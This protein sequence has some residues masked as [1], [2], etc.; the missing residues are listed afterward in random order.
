MEL[1]TVELVLNFESTFQV[2]IPDPEAE[3]MMT[4]RH[5]TDFIVSQFEVAEGGPVGL[6]AAE[7]DAARSCFAHHLALPE[8]L[9]QKLTRAD[10]AM[11]VRH[12]TL[13]QLGLP[14]KKYDEDKR[15][16]EDFGVD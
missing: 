12:I 13:C 8:Q 15:F 1:D 4:P 10:V 14:E 6:A 16:V 3:K 11:L 5:V 7:V 2:F 9:R